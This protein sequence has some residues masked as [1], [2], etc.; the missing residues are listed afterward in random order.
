MD[1]FGF[2]LIYFF[3]GLAFFSMGL[4]VT[5]EVSMATDQRLQ[6]A[7]RPMGA[8]G[9]I[10][11]VHEWMTMF[12]RIAP[13]FGIDFSGLWLD[14]LRLAILSF[15]FLSLAA[16]GAYLLAKTEEQ[17]R[18]SLLAPLG[19]EAIWIFGLF[20]LR[21]QTPAG[22]L[23]ESADVWT[24]YSLGFPGALLAAIGLVFQQREFR[25]AGMVQFG[26]DTLWAAVAFAW[27]GVMGQLITRPSSLPPST[28]LNDTWFL[29]AFGFPI[30]LFRALMAILA[31]LFI[32]RFL[33]AFQVEHERRIHELQESRLAE[34]REREKLRGQLFQQV[35][36]AQESE[37]QRIARDLHDETGQALTAIGMG[38]RGLST[39]I[40]RG[41]TDQA[42]STLGHLETLAVNSLT[43]LQRLMADLRPS[44]IDDLGLPAAVRWCAKNFESRGVF[45]V[46]VE[47]E[48][49]EH[50]LDDSVKIAIFR[51]LQ[52]SLNNVVKHAN[53]SQVDVRVIY[54]PA[55]VRL[56]IKDNGQGFDLQ[57]VR[58]RK[59]GRVSL[60]L[61][62]MQERASLMGGSCFIHSIPGSG[63]L[64]DVRMPYHPIGLD[65]P[66]ENTTTARR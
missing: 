7:L 18:L 52:E 66:Y 49:S 40:R 12:E 38:L 56:T 64:V 46:A 58:S 35:V 11:G 63:T 21:G 37:R 16:F 3:Y 20:V 1:D 41:S 39:S 51:V 50:P 59:T 4:Q 23:L 13:R 17:Q 62:G 29:A 9:L 15:S 43:E 61:L 42:I 5:F 31:S 33:Q 32:I 22:G 26:R 2:I 24:R 34:A 30:E 48:G 28:F 19:L 8:F 53:A 6:R 54:E 25:R 55:S 45:T 14:A 10:H 65:V 60:G 44:H 36:A 47:I 27:Y 57:Q